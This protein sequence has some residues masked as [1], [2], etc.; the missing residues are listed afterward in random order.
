[1]SRPEEVASKESPLYARLGASSSKRG[2]LHA[3]EL[4][5][6]SAFF[7]EPIAD[8]TG[9]PDYYS[10]LHADGAGTKA[11]VAYLGFRETGDPSWFRGI[12]QDSLVMNLDD[13]AC[14]GAFEN[15]VLSNSIARNRFLVPD[16]AISEIVHGYREVIENLRQFGIHITMAGGETA[17]MGDV[18]RT[19]VVD[20]TLFAR[21]KRA[22]AIST[23][24][25]SNGDCIIG[26]SSS[27]KT[28]YEKKENSGIGSNGLTLARHALIHNSYVKKYPEIVDPGVAHDT[29][30]QGRHSLLDTPPGMSQTVLEALSSPT[31][32][33]APVIKVV[34][35]ELGEAL[36]ACIHC[37]G[38]GQTKISRFGRNM[39]YVKDNL[40]VVPPVFSLIQEAMK[41][42]WQ[43]MYTVFNMGHR[44]EL[45]C[46]EKAAQQ[47]LAICSNF[48][49]DAKVVGHVE[50]SQSGNSV[51]LKTPYG[52][53]FYGNEGAG[54]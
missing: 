18:I 19:V 4:S 16:E 17:D 33:Y 22:N 47:V 43:E 46:V 45:V 5:E 44:M 29:A 25:M 35:E 26:L 24:R 12:A 36:H 38:G 37:S 30:H 40:F 13:I 27:G 10:V 48:G 51:K 2:M 8:V 7:A 14:I 34:A 6:T 23:D 50:E 54:V 32:T 49:L 9:D 41:V 31:R 15:L 53:F 3:L 20:A 11:I 52:E 39:S 42:P 1:M 28:I 21:V